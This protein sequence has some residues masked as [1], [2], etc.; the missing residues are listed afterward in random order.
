MI[1]TSP[2]RVRFF[3]L[4]LEGLGTYVIPD[5]GTFAY[6]TASLWFSRPVLADDYYS[7][8]FFMEGDLGC[9]H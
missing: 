7:F 3:W 2:I 6:C 1:F 5:F 8:K 4:D 9:L